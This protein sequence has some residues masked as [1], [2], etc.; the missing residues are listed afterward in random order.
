MTTAEQ[1]RAEERE[2]AAQ[3]RHME[4]MRR[5][6]ERARAAAE[7]ARDREEARRRRLALTPA[8]RD[9]KA[10][11]REYARAL[12]AANVRSRRP[13]PDELDRALDRAY[14]VAMARCGHAQRLRGWRA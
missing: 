8:E 13:F 11:C 3:H 1:V 2:A 9:A 6:A 10:A 4:R 5:E 12:A 7:E 14:A